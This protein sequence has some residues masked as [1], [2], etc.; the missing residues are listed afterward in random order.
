MQEG[1]K[2]FIDLMV[3]A[4]QLD[5]SLLPAIQ[6]GFKYPEMS[7]QYQGNRSEH[8]PKSLEQ[9]F[10]EAPTFGNRDVQ[11]PHLDRLKA[12]RILSGNVGKT[13][14][15]QGDGS[16]TPALE[17]LRPTPDRLAQQASDALRQERKNQDTARKHTAAWPQILKERSGKA[18]AEEL[19]RAKRDAD[20]AAARNHLRAVTDA[21][22]GQWKAER[23]TEETARQ[24]MLRASSQEKQDNYEADRQQKG[25]LLEG[26]VSTTGTYLQ[27]Q[28][29][30]GRAIKADGREQ[31]DAGATASRQQRAQTA[32][33][34]AHRESLASGS[35]RQETRASP[36]D[37]SRASSSWSISV[38]S[39]AIRDEIEKMRADMTPS[40]LAQPGT[41]HRDRDAELLSKADQAISTANR[42]IAET[43]QRWGRSSIEP[44]QRGDRRRDGSPI[45]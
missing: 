28:A 36:H 20:G 18:R 41:G 33:D 14:P 9:R 7:P 19:A 11:V 3:K 17:A 5:P 12:A 22:Y 26:I 42:H 1:V 10:N 23:E 38:T 40:P 45:N 39:N 8:K 4:S 6:D 32:T 25:M 30:S 21:E 15:A 24:D 16:G 13:Y 2:A 44:P 27:H 43:E 29:Q 31:T 34:R 35:A 37:L